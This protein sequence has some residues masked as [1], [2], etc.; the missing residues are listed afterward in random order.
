M[1][2]EL[3]KTVIIAGVQVRTLLA[4][5]PSSSDENMREHHQNHKLCRIRNAIPVHKHKKKD[6]DRAARI[7]AKMQG[8]IVTCNLTIIAAAAAAYLII[9]WS[10]ASPLA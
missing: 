3:V 6:S 10:R 7:H 2:V 9:G 1:P 4:S 5:S 8:V